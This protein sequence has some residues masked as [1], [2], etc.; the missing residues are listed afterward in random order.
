MKIQYRTIR[1][2]GKAFSESGK[3]HVSVVYNNASVVESLVN[4]DL[5]TESMSDIATEQH[6][7]LCEWQSPINLVGYIPFKICV[8]GG[9]LMFSGI[10]C[11]YI[12]DFINGDP[13][14]EFIPAEDWFYRPSLKIPESDGKD[15]VKINE[16]PQQRITSNPDHLLGDWQWLIPNNGVLT[17]DLYIDPDLVLCNKSFVDYEIKLNYHSISSF[18]HK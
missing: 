15:N 16:V 18:L 13:L 8:T 17:C 11:N 7:I 6:D 10:Q 9:Q 1:M 12:S 4:S 14:D 5:P 2:L 3:M